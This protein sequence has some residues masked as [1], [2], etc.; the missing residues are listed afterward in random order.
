MVH[1]GRETGRYPIGEVVGFVDLLQMDDVLP[2]FLAASWENLALL[3]A[4]IAALAGTSDHGTAD[5]GDRLARMAR[6]LGAIKASCAFIGLAELGWVAHSAERHLRQ[7]QQGKLSPSGRS[8]SLLA[9]AVNAMKR[10]VELME[11]AD[12]DARGEQPCGE[13][14]NEQR[15]SAGGCHAHGSAWACSPGGQRR[16]EYDR[17]ER[18]LGE[19]IR[20]E[21]G[22]ERPLPCTETPALDAHHSMLLVFDVG[23]SHRMA[24]PLSLVV[25]LEQIPRREIE[26]RAEGWVAVY[27]GEVL[28]LFAIEGAEQ[29]EFADPQ[30][31]VVFSEGPGISGLLVDRVEDIVAR[32]LTIENGSRHAGTLGTAV[33]DGLE[34][35]VIDARHYR[36]TPLRSCGIA[37]L[38]GDV[39]V[40]APLGF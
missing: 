6:G 3:E 12:P 18:R 7:M 23:R 24:I 35:D 34:T 17:I 2:P 30:T 25:R 21:R 27:R 11:P 37:D 16:D 14:G 13:I 29:K 33:V 28:P 40:L 1:G 38:S 8:L 10:L 32:P 36:V 15:H 9:S 26:H 39:G 31:V 5:C 4:E 19:Y 22:I 20:G